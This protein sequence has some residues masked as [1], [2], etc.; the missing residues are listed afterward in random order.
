MK[1]Q[2][3]YIFI[4]ILFATAYNNQA[5]AQNPYAD[6]LAQLLT[7]KEIADS[8]RVDILLE[9]SYEHLRSAFGKSLEYA[10]KALKLSRKTK[11]KA[12]EAAC[13]DVLGT[14]YRYNTVLH[15]SIFISY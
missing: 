13:L 9:L 8:N 10:K 3:I 12:Q 14:V 6:S 11:N 5:L 4:F 2:L 1:K 15:I 7:K